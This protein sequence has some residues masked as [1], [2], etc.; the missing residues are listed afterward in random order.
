MDR[1]SFLKHITFGGIATGSSMVFA[2]VADAYNYNYLLSRNAKSDVVFKNFLAL[3]VAR[4]SSVKLPSETGERTIQVVSSLQNEFTNRG[5]N[6]NP[7]PFA[8]RLG[9]PKIPLWG[10][11][12]TESLGPNPGFG[13]VQIQQNIPSPIAFTGSTTAG[14][15]TGMG[16]LAKDEN[17]NPDKLDGLLLPV[18]EGFADWGTWMGEV[19]PKTGESSPL[20]YSSY[21]T[22]FGEVLRIYEVKKPGRGGFGEITLKVDS[23]RR[24]RTFK[25][26]VD[27]T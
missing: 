6:D 3:N 21:V 23:F 2:K 14:I 18:K 25:I 13:T 27:F 7:T 16:I 26:R 15:Q 1:R 9:N 5:F 24:K 19:N 4:D 22:R 11:Q 17:L 12:R 10:R 20:S 8:K